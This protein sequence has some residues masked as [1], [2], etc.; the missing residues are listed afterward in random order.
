MLIIILG[1]TNSGKTF[2]TEKRLFSYVGTREIEVI[3]D[4]L[5]AQL[6]DESFIKKASNSEVTLV[7]EAISDKDIPANLRLQAD[8]CIFMTRKSLVDYFDRV[9]NDCLNIR[10]SRTFD[11]TSAICGIDYNA[12][13]YDRDGK[14]L[15]IH[16]N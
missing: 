10:N 5:P 4:P 14:R 11:A 1:E 3:R 7:I 13:A 12:I 8:Y 9:V 6:K 15:I 16:F 2:F